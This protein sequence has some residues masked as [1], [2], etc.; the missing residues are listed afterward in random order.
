ME[1]EDA[2]LVPAITE[3][4]CV[5]LLTDLV[6]VLQMLLQVLHTHV[7]HAALD[8]LEEGCVARSGAGTVP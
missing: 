7:T 2:H 1:E 5:L 4:F 8:H 6:S 3:Q